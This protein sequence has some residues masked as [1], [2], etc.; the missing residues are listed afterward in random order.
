MVIPIE[1]VVA[2]VLVIVVLTA[3]K[4]VRAKSGAGLRGAKRLVERMD[5][6]W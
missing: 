3:I 1:S 2:A 4:S 6:E 5:G